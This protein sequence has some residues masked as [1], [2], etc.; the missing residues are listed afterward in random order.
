MEEM[1][2]TD[3]QKFCSTDETRPSIC[4]PFS[5]GTWTY[6]T[7]GRVIVRVPRMAEVPEYPDSPAN[8]DKHIFGGN[9]ITEEWF[10]IP[11]DISTEPEKCG[12]CKGTGECECECGNVHD[13]GN[14]EGSGQSV[15]QIKIKVGT[16]FAGHMLLNLVST[17]PG[18]EICNSKKHAAL[19]IRFDGGDGR[20]MPMKE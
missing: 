3:L 6:S 10:K 5:Q 11:A 15:C 9:P 19:G 1:T 13:C 2:L 12:R 14:C 17:L 7:D 20:F 4:R 16:Q 8:C 18:V